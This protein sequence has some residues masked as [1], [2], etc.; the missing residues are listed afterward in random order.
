MCN[1]T[2]GRSGLSRPHPKVS[3][4]PAVQLQKNGPCCPLSGSW[5]RAWSPWN[6]LGDR[7]DF[8]PM[9]WLL[10][11]LKSCRMG[12]WHQ[13]DPVWL[14][15]QGYQRPQDFLDRDR[16]GGSAHGLSGAA[17]GRARELLLGRSPRA[18]ALHPHCSGKTP[19]HRRLPGLTMH[20]FLWRAGRT[21]CNNL[22]SVNMC[23]LPSCS[24]SHSSKSLNPRRGRGHPDMRLLGQKY[25]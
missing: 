18:G 12:P 13:G 9:R 20:P 8:F 25:R 10:V 21:L 3:S 23:P 17:H 11:P 15:A 2:G 4:S 24:P 6:F 7:S 1:V 14:G 5:L 22:V 16:A 19:L